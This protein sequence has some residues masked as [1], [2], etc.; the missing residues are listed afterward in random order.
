LDWSPVFDI[1]HSVKETITWYK[2]YY[3]QTNDMEEFSK[4]CISYYS[5]KAT[6]LGLK[7]AS[8]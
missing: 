8:E 6:E 5:K 7:W 4:N 2:K 3:E 1:D